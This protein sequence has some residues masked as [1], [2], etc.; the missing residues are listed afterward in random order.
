MRGIWDVSGSNSPVFFIRDPLKFPDLIHTQKRHPQ[1][2]VHDLNAYWDFLS[3]C[4]ESLH[5]V[6][7]LFSDRGIPKGYCHM[8]GYSSHTM[9]MVNAKG[10]KDL[11]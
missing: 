4:P 8:N 7:L 1:T 3:L 5:H 10:F 2:N 11:F 9:K 6:A